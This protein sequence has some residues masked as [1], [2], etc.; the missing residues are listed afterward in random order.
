MCWHTLPISWKYTEY[1]FLTFTLVHSLFPHQYWPCLR[2]LFAYVDQNEAA[3]KENPCLSM[4]EAKHYYL[5]SIWD[6]KV[7]YCQKINK[8]LF[9]LMTHEKIQWHLS[10]IVIYYQSQ[11][12]NKFQDIKNTFLKD[13]SYG[14]YIL[15]ANSDNSPRLFSECLIQGRKFINAKNLLRQGYKLPCLWQS[16]DPVSWTHIILYWLIQSV[17]QLAFTEY[18]LYARF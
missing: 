9:H 8:S 18:L 7:K 14:L 15:T 1:S 12:F 17:N 16:L 5:N 13:I 4:T 10:V 11:P 2:N 3:V 6:R